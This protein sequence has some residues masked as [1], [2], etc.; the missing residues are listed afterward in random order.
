MDLPGQLPVLDGSNGGGHLHHQVW[1]ILIGDL[2]PGS[3]QRSGEGDPVG[4]EAGLAGG[5]V[6]GFPQCVVDQEK[7]VKLLLDAGRITRVQDEAVPSLVR[8]DLIECVLD[9]PPLVIMGS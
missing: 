8:L 1:Q 7:S 6:D 4:I 3:V 9:L 2:P 5:V